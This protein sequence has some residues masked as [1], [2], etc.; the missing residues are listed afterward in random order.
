M[1]MLNTAPFLSMA[2]RGSVELS[3]LSEEVDLPSEAARRASVKI[4]P[5]MV[6]DSLCGCRVHDEEEAKPSGPGDQAN[7]TLDCEK[8]RPALANPQLGNMRGLLRDKTFELLHGYIF[9]F[10]CENAYEDGR[11]PY[12]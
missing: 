8:I 9:A 12:S 2:V 3:M 5:I 6:P 7:H 10:E 11:R 1:L 4:E